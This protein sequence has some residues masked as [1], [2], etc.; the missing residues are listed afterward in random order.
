M[1]GK[2]FKTC[3]PGYPVQSL[4]FARNT[5][6]D[7]DEQCTWRVFRSLQS[8]N[9][10]TSR[11]RAGGISMQDYL[12]RTSAAS[13]LLYG[14]HST[15]S[16]SWQS[17]RT[18]AAPNLVH[19]PHFT[20]SPSYIFLERFPSSPFPLYGNQHCVTTIYMSPLP[21]SCS[22]LPLHVSAN[23]VGSSSALRSSP[24]SRKSSIQ[25]SN[26]VLGLD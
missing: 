22:L 15:I 4:V 2:L 12:S 26:T 21:I 14:K 16:P 6:G 8:L 5:A 11:G 19:R 1:K 20:V 23:C 17:F 10:S 9:H 13:D 18:S 3:V 25:P 24:V 7:I